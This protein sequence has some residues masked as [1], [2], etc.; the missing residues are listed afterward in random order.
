[1]IRRKTLGLTFVLGAASLAF[2]QQKVN[3]SGIIADRQNAAVPY[4]SVTFSHK[5][6]KMFSDAAL[7][8]EK[9]AY[10][11]ALVPGTYDITIEAIDY[12]KSVLTKEI[13]AAGN[14][15]VLTIEAE[16]SATNGRT[17]DIQGVVITAAAVKP[18]R[19]ELD[20]KVYD[21]STDIIRDRKSV[22]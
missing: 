7:T 2:A 22:V 4:A 19:V 1:M 9:G 12:K 15:G 17:Q 21:P 14:L 3:V 6:N 11:L 13:T 20:K 8:D 16:S 10:S 18:Y 5:T